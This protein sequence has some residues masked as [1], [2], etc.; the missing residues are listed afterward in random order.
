MA[1]SISAHQLWQICAV[2]CENVELESVC[3]HKVLL[4]KI[5]LC[6]QFCCEQRTILKINIHSE[7]VK[8]KIW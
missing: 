3:I 8:D 6:D 4:G 1:L 5:E 7:I 2:R